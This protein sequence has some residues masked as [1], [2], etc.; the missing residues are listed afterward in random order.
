M[1]GLRMPDLTIL[2]I[3]FLGVKRREE[4]QLRTNA[5]VR[6]DD[7]E[8]L[9]QELV[10]TDLRHQVVADRLLRGDRTL[11]AGFEK[12]LIL[13]SICAL[14]QWLRSL[15]VGELVEAKRLQMHDVADVEAEN[16][17][18]LTVVFHSQGTACCDFEFL[19]DL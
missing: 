17:V 4:A 13:L 19:L 7:V 15:G 11:N 10:F 1:D 18:V 6:N 5:E 3:V 2:Q 16:P 12:G 9:V 14:H 8:W